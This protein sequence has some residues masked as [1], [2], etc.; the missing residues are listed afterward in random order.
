MTQQAKIEAALWPMN[1][2]QSYDS[3]WK[4]GDDV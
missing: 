1:L 3:M 2:T 4:P